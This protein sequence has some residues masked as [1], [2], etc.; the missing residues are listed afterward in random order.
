LGAGAMGVTVAGAV[1]GTG[2][3]GMVG[4]VQ[5]VGKVV[6]QMGKVVEVRK[7][8][9]PRILKSDFRR[10]YVN[11][12]ANV[13][14]SAD[15]D[16][17]TSHLQTYYHPDLV[18]KQTFVTTCSG[19]PPMF[20]PTS[21]GLGHFGKFL[22][23]Y[24]TFSPDIMCAVKHTVLK[25]RADGTSCIRFSFELS[26]TKFVTADTLP[27]IHSCT[28]NM[29]S[30]GMKVGSTAAAVAA[31]AP[32]TKYFRDMKE[33]EKKQWKEKP[34]RRGR[35]MGKDVGG[36]YGLSGHK[37]GDGKG[38]R[39]G[40][41]QK[42]GQQFTA[43]SY[44]DWDYLGYLLD[45]ERT[46]PPTPTPTPTPIPT[47]PIPSITTT[48][49]TTTTATHTTTTTTTITTNPPQQQQQVAPIPVVPPVVTPVGFL[50]LC[51]FELELDELSRIFAVNFNY[52]PGKICDSI[53]E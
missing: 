1:T 15:T 44:D 31:V 19:R 36:R 46:T 25:V 51:S 47:I 35:R 42:D 7:L 14:N 53:C 24:T 34:K 39:R 49:T 22:H 48:T 18:F 11:M 4:E 10:N 23:H 26:G 21:Q 6:G 20:L 17:V 30:Q 38:G 12:W 32:D 33:K 13:F 2:S 37:D 3:Q 5:N 9:R 28:Q 50:Q 52:M 41:G 43:D 29:E 27:D 8:P 40:D 16:M 45:D